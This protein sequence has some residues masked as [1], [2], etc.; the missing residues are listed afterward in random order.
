MPAFDKVYRLLITL[1]YTLR[2]TK[3]DGELVAFLGGETV[4]RG[5]KG[6]IG[7]ARQNLKDALSEIAFLG[8]KNLNNPPVH[9]D[10]PALAVPLEISSALDLPE[11]SLLEDAL[12]AIEALAT[13]SDDGLG[14]L[15]DEIA[16]LREAIKRLSAGLP[17]HLTGEN[18]ER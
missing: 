17:T 3:S 14:A 16:A 9:S 1:G 5:A 4:P 8:T 15:R 7:T 2:I 11:D 6:E 18:D 13:R 10:N 12:A